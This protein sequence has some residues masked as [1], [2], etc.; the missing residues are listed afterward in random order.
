MWWLIT[1]V[2]CTIAGLF[3]ATCF[4]FAI[5]DYGDNKGVFGSGG[6]PRPR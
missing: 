4:A 3:F 6:G 1:A 5:S 2:V